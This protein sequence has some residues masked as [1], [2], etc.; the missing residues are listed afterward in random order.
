M[1]GAAIILLVFA[2]LVGVCINALTNNL[3]YALS[4]TIVV[5]GLIFFVAITRTALEAG[6]YTLDLQSR[7]SLEAVHKAQKEKEQQD[8]FSTGW[9]EQS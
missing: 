7:E 9:E 8:K 5:V 4:T 1:I 3:F 2:F 6:D